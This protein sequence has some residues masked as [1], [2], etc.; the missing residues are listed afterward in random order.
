Q[1][2]VSNLHGPWL[3]DVVASVISM[4]AVTL[5]LRVW[6]PRRHWGL[7]GEEAGPP[8]P[9][10]ATPPARRAVL[11]AWGPWLILSARGFAW[12][13][14]QARAW[15]DGIALLRGPVPG[16]HNLVERVPPVV[17]TRRPEPA[18]YVLNSLSATGSG[19]FVASLIAGLVMGYRPLEMA[20]V[21][22]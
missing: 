16:L 10:V 9:G 8:R 13:L 15:L 14:A 12:G 4:V 5:F 22:G 20:R 3:V 18:L 11:P 6:Q 17:P 7:E 19:I 1:L 21:Y 2:L